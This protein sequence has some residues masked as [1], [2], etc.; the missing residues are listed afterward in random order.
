MAGSLADRGGIELVRVWLRARDSDFGE[1]AGFVHEMDKV[2]QT[3]VGVKEGAEGE[4]VSMENGVVPPEDVVE[5]LVA[6]TLAY[7]M[8]S[9]L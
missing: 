5:G 9:C 4:V 7:I 6:R 1:C 8:M 2:V 3:V